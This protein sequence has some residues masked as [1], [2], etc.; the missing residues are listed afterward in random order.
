MIPCR[1]SGLCYIP[2]AGVDLYSFVLA[3]AVY[4]ISSKLQ[5]L[6]TLPRAAAKILRFYV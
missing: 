2:P 1:A 5:N 6:P 3:L 4:L